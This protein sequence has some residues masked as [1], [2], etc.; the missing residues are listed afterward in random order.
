[1]L[2][3]IEPSSV[4]R[5]SAAPYGAGECCTDSHH[6]DKPSCQ[7]TVRWSSA[8]ARFWWVDPGCAPAARK[9]RCPRS[10]PMAD[11]DPLNR[12][13]VEQMLVG[14][15]TRR[16]ARSLEPSSRSG[17]VRTCWPICR[18]AACARTGVC[19]SSSMARRPCARRCARSSATRPWCSAVNTHKTRN[20]LEYLSDRNRPWA[21][22][23]LRRA[24]QAPDVKKAQCWL[25]R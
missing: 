9:S 18:A 4:G 6:H 25:S 14:V 15:A 21:Q 8:G 23:I 10:G 24:Y 22:A 3:V 2:P 12:R 5:A 11:V 17:C 1:M 7:E 16:Y 19:W 20:V 13:V